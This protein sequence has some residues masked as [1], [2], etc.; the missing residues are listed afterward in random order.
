MADAALAEGITL[1]MHTTFEVIRSGVSGDIVDGDGGDG[2]D[3]GEGMDF[4]VS[5]ISTEALEAKVRVDI[6]SRPAGRVS[7]SRCCCFG[8]NKFN[9]RT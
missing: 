2:A 8:R 7:S 5:V 6:F 4:I 1:P 9:W 3:G